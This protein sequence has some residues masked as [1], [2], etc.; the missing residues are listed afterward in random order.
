MEYRMAVPEDA[1]ALSAFAREARGM[2]FPEAFWDWKYF[3]NPF[4]PSGLAVA[5]DDGRIV[6]R[7][8]VFAMP[9]TSPWGQATG[10]QLRDSDVLPAYR[11]GG[12]LFHLS[13]T[14][15]GQAPKDGWG[16]LMFG[17]A[18]QATRDV[19]V[20]L[21]GF[22]EVERVHKFVRI[23]DPAPFLKR[24]LPLPGLRLLICPLAVA[25]RAAARRGQT[26]PVRPLDVAHDLSLD[27]RLAWRTGSGRFGVRKDARYLR[28]R[29][30]T[31]PLL[32]YQMGW[33]GDP[34]H[35][36]GMLVWHTACR[37]GVRYTILDECLMLPEA[38]GA[39]IALAQAA[40]EGAEAVLAWAMTPSDAAAELARAGY[41]RR[42]TPF[43]LVARGSEDGPE[44]N[45]VGDARNWDFQLGDSDTWLVPPE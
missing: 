16:D 36:T 34:D 40:E 26:L 8:G 32:D 9:F 6:A 18:I 5:V 39:G 27:P 28:W 20:D 4:G 12:T 11:S 23:L 43:F 30:A 22:H 35:P 42:P 31:C 24:R 3:Q 45:A 2:E 10:C 25:R 7:S 33:V 21:I 44:S 13:S 29:Y 41:E 38:E 15:L 19:C 17:V 37:E 1:P 14:L